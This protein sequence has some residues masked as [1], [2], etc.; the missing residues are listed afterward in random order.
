MGVDI[1]LHIEI[2]KQNQWNL[3]KV[4]SPQ[5]E[6]P[7]HEYE[8]FNSEVFNCR[9]YHFRDFLEEADSHRSRNKDI[10]SE[11]VQKLIDDDDYNMGF[12]VFMFD[13]LVHHC[14]SLEKKLLSGIAHAGI[15]S[16]KEQLNRIEAKLNNSPKDHGATEEQDE[17]YEDVTPIE[18]MYEDFMWDYGLLFRFRDTVQAL[19]SF[20]YTHI[21]ESDV[22]IFY[23]VC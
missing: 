4:T 15:Y 2:R 9:Y 8:I 3:M 11:E 6:K 17:C 19:T 1:S 13:D 14:D 21:N 7:D 5:W 12:G 10:L 18:Q 20:G 16:I 23:I 22:R